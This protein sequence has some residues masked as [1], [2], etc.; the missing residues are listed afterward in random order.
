MEQGGA[1]RAEFRHGHVEPIKFTTDSPD[2]FETAMEV[3]S[4]PVSIQPEHGSPFHAEVKLAKLP[5][6]GIFT[7]RPSA[8]RVFIP[9]PLEFLSITVPL[10]EYFT[11]AERDAGGA[12]RPG[13]AHIANLDR[14][15]DIRTVDGLQ[16]LVMN[17]DAHLLRSYRAK[18]NGGEPSGALALCSRLS[19]TTP[20]GASFWRYTSF[21]W[22]E[23]GHGSTS[24]QSPIIA[25]EVEDSL[26]AMFL[27]ASER[28]SPDEMKS[29]VVGIGST[30][31]RRAEEFIF[32]RL[33]EPLSV[34]DVAEISGVNAR[35]LSRA[36]KKR[37]GMGPMA[38]LKERR[39]EQ[40]Q[41]AL[42][43]ADSESTTVTEIATRL[44]FYHLGQFSKDYRQAFQELPSETLRR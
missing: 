30:Y 42:L 4:G 28:V 18:L 17:F 29:R 9:E 15:F 16:V 37:Y 27:Y 44:G 31:L 43:G 10:V 24:L 19:L 7:V 34:A 39:L 23:L 41:R 3:V 36:F 14:P 40:A 5:R 26:L 22:S 33:S 25:R 13:M 8:M 20:E 38:F 2:Y 32:A 1:K 6:L 35:T 12:I 21:L 11:A